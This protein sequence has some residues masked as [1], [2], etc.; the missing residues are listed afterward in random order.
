MKFSTLFWLRLPRSN[1]RTSALVHV[2]LVT[3]AR[4]FGNANVV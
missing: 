4:Y 1:L 3:A 2:S